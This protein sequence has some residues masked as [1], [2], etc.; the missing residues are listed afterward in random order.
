MTATR[1][2]TK[3][4]YGYEDFRLSAQSGSSELGAQGTQQSTCTYGGFAEYIV[5]NNQSYIQVASIP[6]DYA[7]YNVTAIALHISLQSTSQDAP[8][9]RNGILHCVR[10][11]TS[12]T[13]NAVWFDVFE[14]PQFLF[15][16]QSANIFQYTSANLNNINVFI[17]LT[18]IRINAGGWYR[19][20][21]LNFV[22][23]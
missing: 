8:A 12:L 5:G 13:S 6:I 4:N 21:E 19:K 9:A 16:A 22:A 17:P 14:E 15:T 3:N 18:Q 23:Q 2:N 7:N 20:Y 10:R 11:G 1:I